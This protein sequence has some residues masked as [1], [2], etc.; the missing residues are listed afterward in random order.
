MT[1][2]PRQFASS[3]G[4]QA[5]LRLV[6]SVFLAELIHS[7]LDIYLV[8]PWVSDF[9]L[10]DNRDGKFQ[11][12]LPTLDFRQLSFSDV[13][14]TLIK[15][16][17][18]L[19]LVTRPLESNSQFIAE[20]RRKVPADRILIHEIEGWGKGGNIHE[21]GLLFR[22]NGLERTVY[23]AGSMNFTYSG[24]EMNMEAVTLHIGDGV[25]LDA[26]NRMRSRWVEGRE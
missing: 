9:H 16:G 22:S 5:L 8:S 23:L 20:I 17:S 12:L 3:E 2:P 4:P 21:K 19:T 1:S 10:L 25:A 7:S 14:S 15:R 18:S 26:Y 13:L 6:R 11:R 24:V